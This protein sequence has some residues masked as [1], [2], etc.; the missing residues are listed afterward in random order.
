MY[1]VQL[2]KSYRII[3]FTYIFVPC[4]RWFAKS[5]PDA[6]L[7]LP[8]DG[9]TAD[10]NH[11]RFT[12]R[13]DKLKHSFMMITNVD[14]LY[15]PTR[16]NYVILSS[17]TCAYKASTS[18]KSSPM[19][20]VIDPFSASYNH[21]YLSILFYYFFFPFLLFSVSLPFY[22][23]ISYIGRLGNTVLIHFTIFIYLFIY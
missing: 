20:S 4:C 19:E 13:N 23:M 8:G 21:F 6:V 17:W 10:P 12:Y 9:P 14:R 7:L 1:V 16:Y 18:Y 15:T 2:Y 11:L 3:S 22:N 5:L